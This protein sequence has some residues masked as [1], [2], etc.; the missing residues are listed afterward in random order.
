[1]ES[2]HKPDDI[3]NTKTAKSIWAKD[4]KITKALIQLDN[5]VLRFWESELDADPEKNLSSEILDSCKKYEKSGIRAVCIEAS[6][7]GS[8]AN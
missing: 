3:I 6:K 4:R 7:R 2:G 5:Q 8:N 1:M